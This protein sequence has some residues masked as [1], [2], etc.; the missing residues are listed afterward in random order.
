MSV[1]LLLALLASFAT[2]CAA[3]I[4]FSDGQAARARRILLY[5]TAGATAYAAV[6]IVVAMLP[7]QTAF[8]TGAP[9]CD[10]DVCIS[11]DKITRTET[12]VRGDV[13]MDVRLSSLANHG[14]RSTAGAS[15]Y[16]IDDRNNRY[17]CS[18]PFDF[19][20]AP[21]QSL[22]T[23]LIFNVPSGAQNLSFAASMDHLRYASFIIGIG[24]L[25]HR[26][27]VQFPLAENHR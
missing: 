7:R 26:P 2:L 13:R 8:K 25:L 24:D 18:S 4:L 1:V 14:P 17:P 3:V 27:R 6:L 11:V 16:L 12:S 23:T 20:L 9:Y 21:R 5:W 19:T 15:A 22:S 10:D